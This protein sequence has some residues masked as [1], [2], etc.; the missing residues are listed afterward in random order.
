MNAMIPLGVTLGGLGAGCWAKKAGFVLPAR[1]FAIFTLFLFGI[2]I[3]FPLPESLAGVMMFLIGCGFSASTLGLA[4]IHAHLPPAATA[5]ATSLAVTASC[6]FGGVI[7]PLVGS[8]IA[9]PH[10]ASGLLAL[11]HGKTPDFASYQRGLLWLMGSVAV[12]VAASFLFRPAPAEK[13]G[14]PGSAVPSRRPAA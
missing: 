3:F 4:A 9:A 12:A 8:A 11:V 5:L 14:Q 7:Q 6:I 1:L 2:L 13:T 10:R